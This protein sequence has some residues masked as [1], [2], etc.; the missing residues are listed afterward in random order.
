MQEFFT[1]FENNYNDLQDVTQQATVFVGQ[2]AILN[3]YVGNE[4]LPVGVNPFKPVPPEPE[5]TYGLSP[6]WIVVLTLLLGALLAFLGYA[7]YRWQ[8]AK[9]ERAFRERERLNSSRQSNVDQMGSYQQPTAMNI[10]Y[11]GTS[12]NAG[13]QRDSNISRPT[14]NQIEIEE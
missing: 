2:N 9:A 14:E 6:G 1:V 12:S 8:S 11:S 3:A 7:L 5:P 4:I 10:N 13:I